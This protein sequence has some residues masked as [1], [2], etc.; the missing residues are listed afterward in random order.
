MAGPPVPQFAVNSRTI[1]Y[2]ARP[3]WMEADTASDRATATRFVVKPL[4]LQVRDA[5]IARIGKGEWKPGMAL[6][7]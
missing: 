7:C 1:S 4:Y 6:S 3:S 5:M 2:P